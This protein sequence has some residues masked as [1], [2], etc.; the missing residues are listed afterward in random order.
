M[1]ELAGEFKVRPWLFRASRFTYSLGALD[2][3]LAICLRRISQ[4]LPAIA[5]SRSLRRGP[6]KSRNARSSRQ[7]A[8]AVKHQTYRYRCRFKLFQHRHQES[9]IL[10]GNNLVGQDPGQSK[11]CDGCVNCSF[12][13]VDSQTGTN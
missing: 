8:L 7:R 11:A 3:W 1:L 4:D 12:R 13:C 2:I 6:A 10:C 9:G 5:K